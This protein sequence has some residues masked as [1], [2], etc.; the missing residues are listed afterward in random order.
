MEEGVRERRKAFAAAYRS[1]EDCQVYISAF[2]HASDAIT[3]AVAGDMLISFSEISLFSPP[4]YYWFF[5][6]SLTSPTV[7]IAGSMHRSMPTTSD[8]IFLFSN[9]KRCVAAR[10]YLSELHQASCP[11]RVSFLSFLYQ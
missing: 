10:G 3:K 2:Q 9:Q 1:D 11:Q 7:L 4:F 5:F 8:L 6:L